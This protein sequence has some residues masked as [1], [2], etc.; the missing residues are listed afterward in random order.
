M[1]VLNACSAVM[2]AA[3]KA[4]IATE[5]INAR[6]KEMRAPRGQFLQ[7]ILARHLAS[8]AFL[9]FEITLPVHLWF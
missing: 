2:Q 6:I 1:D 7:T 3:S 9:F 8:R 5:G 4:G